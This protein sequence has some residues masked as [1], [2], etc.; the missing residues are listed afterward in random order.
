GAAGGN[1]HH[2]N[3]RSP[4]GRKIIKARADRAPGR[5]V[6]IDLRDGRCAYG[7]QLTGVT[8]EFYDR[9]GVPGELVNLIET[10]A[11]PVAFRIWVMDCAFRRGGG[12]EL[13]DV[14]PLSQEERAEVHH[15]A[16]QDPLSGSLTLY[17]VDPA[18]GT[19]VETSASME[20]CPG[21]GA[22][23]GLEP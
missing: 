16:K 9:I 3:Q 2:V 11:A 19:G 14:V 17:S 10:I 1:N 4:D 15:Y 20:E 22:C 23:C 7:R 12:W 13:L 18:S 6:R 5:V 21:F 8:V